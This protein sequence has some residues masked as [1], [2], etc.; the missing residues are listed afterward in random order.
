MKPNFQS[1]WYWMIKLKKI[2]LKKDKIN[3]EL[4]DLT[5]ASCHKTV[6]FPKKI[7]KQK[8]WSSFSN[9]PNVEALN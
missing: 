2:Q 1:T 6:I 7:N 9:Q 3:P 5:H 4:I 8:L